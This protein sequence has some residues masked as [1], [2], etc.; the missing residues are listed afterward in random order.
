MLK[1]CFAALLLLALTGCFESANPHFPRG[2]LV[3][4]P[5]LLGRHW[6]IS[7]ENGEPSLEGFRRA[8]RGGM[9]WDAD[10]KS[11]APMPVQLARLT[12][13]GAYLFV[14]GS[15]EETVNYLMLERWDNGVWTSNDFDLNLGE[16][17]AAQNAAFIN[18]VAARHGLKLEGGDSKRIEGKITAAAVLGLFR[19]PDF[20][21]AVQLPAGG[22]YLPRQI[23]RRKIGQ[24]DIGTLP[25]NGALS[26]SLTGAGLTGMARPQGLAGHYA[27]FRATS[28]DEPAAIDLRQRADG[29]FEYSDKAGVRIALGVVPFDAQGNA[30]IAVEDRK[31][32]EGEQE[33][34]L[35]GLRLLERETYGWSLH[36][37]ALL[38]RQVR[39]EI[40][41]MRTALLQR[42]AAA[43]GLEWEV[44]ALNPDW[45]GL[46]QVRDGQALAA[47]LRDGQFTS[48]LAIDRVNYERFYSGSAMRA[49]FPAQLGDGSP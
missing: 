49:L 14:I 46:T 12:S 35:Y 11:D 45:S 32:G 42:A 13:G 28:W 39:P 29:W 22:Y 20:L 38:S 36:D 47:L 43:H 19:D 48:A 15:N 10:L 44:N 7:R 40:V 16:P 2:E 3:Q 23:G 27:N 1:R 8:A 21:G 6:A 33:R 5:D 9:L 31:Y 30:W 4:P 18:A 34:H 37:I 25:Q 24:L 17:F 26:V 41:A